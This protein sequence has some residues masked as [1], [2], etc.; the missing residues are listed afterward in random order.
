MPKQTNSMYYFLTFSEQSLST[1]YSPLEIS[2]KFCF[3]AF[4]ENGN[5]LVINSSDV[6]F[7]SFYF[8]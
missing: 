7:K 4:D 1:Q 3:D 5:R 8:F 2:Q 6:N